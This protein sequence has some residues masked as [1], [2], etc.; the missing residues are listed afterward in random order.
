MLQQ[1]ERDRTQ[2]KL[3]RIRELY[4]DGAYSKAEYQLKTEQTQ[5]ILQKISDAIQTI[6]EQQQVSTV[7]RTAYIKQTYSK[8]EPI[9]A[10]WSKETLHAIIKE[11]RAD[12]GTVTVEMINGQSFLLTQPPHLINQYK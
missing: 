5:A 7:I 4:T 12:H 6:E 3:Q 8:G 11:I 2:Q 10:S 1:Q 9:E